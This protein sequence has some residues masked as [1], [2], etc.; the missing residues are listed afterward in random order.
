M[1]KYIRPCRLQYSFVYG[2]TGPVSGRL[3][4]GLVRICY[5]VGFTFTIGDRKRQVSPEPIAHQASVGIGTE[6]ICTPWTGC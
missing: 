1:G 4:N 3:A 6:N 5:Y 2:V